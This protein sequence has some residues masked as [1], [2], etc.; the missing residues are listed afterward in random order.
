MKINNLVAG[1]L[2]LDLNDYKTTKKKVGTTNKSSIFSSILRSE[3]I[4][5]DKHFIVLENGE[6]NLELIKYMLDK[7][8]N[9]GEKL[10]SEPSRQ[11]V[12]F[13]RKAI[14]EFLSVVLSFSVSLKEQR[15]G[16]SGEHKR[17]KYRIVRII[18]EKLDKLAY[19]VLQ[20]Q[21]SQIKL[22]SSLEEIQGLLVNL[23]R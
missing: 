23:L 16:N 7:I 8:N 11:N 4:K 10:L 15:G 14:G 3:L 22:L 18:N 13:Y 19:S 20:N 21:V 17:P 5:E 9:V 1:A 6:F 2:N 12:V